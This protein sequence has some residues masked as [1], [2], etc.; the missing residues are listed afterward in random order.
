MSIVNGTSPLV[1]ADCVR[2]AMELRAEIR[3][4][5]T[6]LTTPWGGVRYVLAIDGDLRFQQDVEFAWRHQRLG[7]AAVLAKLNHFS[8][9]FD[10]LRSIVEADPMRDS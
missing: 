6:A 3:R 4:K 9:L 1:E 10:E 5:Q 8:S 2:L 7:E